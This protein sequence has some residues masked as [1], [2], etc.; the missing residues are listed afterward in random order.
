MSKLAEHLHK[1]GEIAIIPTD[2]VYGVVARAADPQAVGRLYQLKHR[3]GKPGTL[4][5]ATTDQL[6][7]LGIKRD[8]LK[9]AEALWPRALSIIIPCDQNLSYLHQGTNSLAIRIPDDSRLVKLLQQ[10]GPLLTSSANQPGEPPSTTIAEAKVYFGDQVD[11]Y[12]D[13]GFVNREPSTV[14]K[15]VNHS[16]EVIRP[17]AVKF[18]ESIARP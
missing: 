12:E 18:D 2:T 3:E 7:E 17:G 4:V 5:A 1:H 13:G 8:H 14:I 10:T 6:V 15:I 16:I 11:W 9:M